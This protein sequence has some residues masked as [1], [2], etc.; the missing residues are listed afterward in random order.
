[1]MFKTDAACMETT[2]ERMM[3]RVVTVKCIFAKVHSALITWL[4]K[5]R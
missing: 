1:M 2:R 5:E 4:K 3:Q